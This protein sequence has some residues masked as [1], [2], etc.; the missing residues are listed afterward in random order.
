[1]HFGIHK[2]DVDYLEEKNEKKCG[3]IVYLWHYLII[4]NSRT[5]ERKEMIKVCAIITHAE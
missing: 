5:I 2:Y 1:V 3:H 4:S